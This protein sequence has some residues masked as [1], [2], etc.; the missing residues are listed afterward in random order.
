[1]HGEVLRPGPALL[2]PL[3]L[4][5]TPHEVI[6]CRPCAEASHDPLHPRKERL[7]V[8]VGS[9]GFYWDSRGRYP[10][11]ARRYGTLAGK[12]RG[13]WVLCHAAL[14]NHGHCGYFARDGQIRFTRTLADLDSALRRGDLRGEMLTSEP[15]GN[16]VGTLHGAPANRLERALGQLRSQLLDEYGLPGAIERLEALLQGQRFEA[17]VKF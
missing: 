2:R 15:L 5:D 12:Q 14:C 9:W 17:M 3:G 10:D 8:R 7:F 11:D 4:Q 1:M 6:Y 16:D 13:R